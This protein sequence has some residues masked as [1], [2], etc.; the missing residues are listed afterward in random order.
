M[1]RPTALESPIEDPLHDADGIDPDPE[2]GSFDL[3]ALAQRALVMLQADGVA[4]ALRAAEGVICCATAGNLAP[5]EGVPVDQESG[6]TGECMRTRR[7]V[8]CADT[9]HDAR[10]SA[11]T[12][13]AGIGSVMV[14]PVV[15]GDVVTG[16]VEALWRNAHAFNDRDQ[17]VLESVAD[18]LLAGQPC[19]KVTVFDSSLPL[20]A[21]AEIDIPGF[22]NIGTDRPPKLHQRQRKIQLMVLAVIIASG[23]LLSLVSISSHHQ[24]ERHSSPVPEGSAGNQQLLDS[25]RKSAE[26][27]NVGAQSSLANFYWTGKGVPQDNIN[28]YM[29]SIIAATHGDR[30]SMQRLEMLRTTMSRES[31]NAAEHRANTWLAQHRRSKPE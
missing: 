7:V 5:D 26:E 6:L 30:N 1:A 22:L 10:V 23:I 9:S 27:G 11:S 16:V 19:P 28:A 25:L 24:A 14:V 8:A 4:I 29:W 2:I 31:V 13:A 21:A 3:A 12:A 15:C 20:Q 18:E 17:R